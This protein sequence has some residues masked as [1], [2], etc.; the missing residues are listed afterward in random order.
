[1]SFP[2][3]APSGYRLPEWVS[4]QDGPVCVVLD[5]SAL[6]VPTPTPDPE[7][8]PST[9]PELQELQAEVSGFRELSLYSAGML[10]CLLAMIAFRT[11]ADR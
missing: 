8:E 3:P 9:T 11:R 10:L 5:V 7:P 1:M 6:Q 4:S 2:D